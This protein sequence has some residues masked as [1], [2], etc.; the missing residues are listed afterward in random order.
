MLRSVVALFAFSAAAFAQAPTVT[1]VINS[2]SLGTQLCPGMLASVYGTNFG[3]DASAVSVSVGETSAY[4][5]A[6]IVATQINIQ[7]PYGLATGATTLTVTVAGVQSAA[8]PITLNTVAPYLVTSNDSGTGLALAYDGSTQ[9]SLAAPVHAGDTVVAYAVGLGPTNP[10]STAGV[11]AATANTATPVTL[12]V[13]T[14]AATVIFAG[15]TKGNG[16]GVYQINFTVPSGVSGT[17]PIV[18]S[19]D[20]VSSTSEGVNSA[21]VTIPVVSTPA[22]PTVTGVQD[23][24]NY[25]ATLCPGLTAIVYGTGFGTIAANVSVSVGGKAGYVIGNVTNNQMLVQIPFEAAT[26]PTTITVTIAGAASA[27]F[28]ITLSA[29]APTFDTQSGTG[30]GLGQVVENASNTLVTLTAPAHVGDSLYAYAVGLGPTN[31]PTATGVATVSSPTATTPTVTVGGVAAKGVSAAITTSYVGTY[32]VNFT[33]P[34]GVQGTV[35]LVIAIDGVSSSSL[36][37]VAVVGVTA[38]VNNASFL[39]PGTVSPGSITTVF[40]NSIGASANVLGGIFPATSS[41]GVMV[42]F[43]GTAASL[44]HVV[45]APSAGNSQQIDLVV[46]TNLPTSGTV[47]VQLTTSTTTYPNYTLNMVPANPGLYRLADPLVPTLVNVIA[48]FNNSTWLA[49]PVSTTANLGLPACTSST[50]VLT[51][52]GQPATVGDILVLYATGL[53]LA[54]PGGSATGS[55]LPNGQ[56]AP[57]SGSPLYETPTTPVVTIGGVPAQ[58]L[59]SGIAPGTAGEYQVDIIVPAGYGYADNVPVVLSILGASDSSTTISVQPR[60]TPPPAVEL[61]SR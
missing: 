13:G 36:V 35:P 15:V 48:Q 28:D 12:T 20:G 58:V 19:I 29:V 22:V 40:A 23:S 37:T 10:A 30:S 39:N 17:V 3:T 34:T 53:G 43:G 24:G 38:V 25:G 26:G 21:T 14:A 41:E 47:N 59:F 55:P 33:V 31:P 52:C 6:T 60:S 54:T 61:G 50:N 49:L 32:Q 4:V 2:G 9:V 42:T 8:F 5:F 11:A 16:G 46:P 56:V 7:I 44:F 51:T 45:G 27:P 57:A 1:S 18:I